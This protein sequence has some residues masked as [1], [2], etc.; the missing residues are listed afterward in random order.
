MTKTAYL[1][2]EVHGSEAVCLKEFEIWKDFYARGF[3]HLFLEIPYFYAQ[4]LNLWMNSEDDLIL[5][6]LWADNK[7]PQEI[8]ILTGNF[9]LK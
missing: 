7:M 8:R 2:G 4:F 6:E 3:R 1:F 9:L 5:D